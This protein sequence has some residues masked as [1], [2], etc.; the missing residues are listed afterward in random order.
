MNNVFRRQ[1]HNKYMPRIQFIKCFNAFI[2][3]GFHYLDSTQL[4][5]LVWILKREYLLP[6]RQE[7]L[8]D[9]I[10]YPWNLLF[11][12]R[13]SIEQPYQFLPFGFQQNHWGK[14]IRLVTASFTKQLLL[15]MAVIAHLVTLCLN[16]W[17]HVTYDC[18]P[19]LNYII[20]QGLPIV[21]LR[22]TIKRSYSPNPS[23]RFR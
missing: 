4:L 15:K 17:L 11:L 1:L 19:R 21:E 13:K 23:T 16:L 2:R 3:D 20:S 5:L 10:M 22:D 9:G 7:T 12:K 18:N 6:F 14:W 8:I